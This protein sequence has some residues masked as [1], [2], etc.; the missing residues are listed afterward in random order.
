MVSMLELNQGLWYSLAMFYL[1]NS[2]DIME[3]Y[4]EK[5]FCFDYGFSTGIGIYAMQMW[6]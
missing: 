3:T 6:E 4:H 2:P 1:K 5:N